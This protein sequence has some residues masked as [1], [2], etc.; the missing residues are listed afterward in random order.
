MLRET[1]YYETFCFFFS[2]FCFYFI[3]TL[4]MPF[5]TQHMPED[6]PTRDFMKL[7]FRNKG[8][9][10]VNIS[11]IFNHKKVTSTIPAYFKNPNPPV[12]S[13]SYLFIAPKLFN[14]KTCCKG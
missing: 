12:V 8:L 2:P 4:H 5:F 11:N 10:A 14:Y 9:D 6:I 7:D 13:Y 3:F 1:G